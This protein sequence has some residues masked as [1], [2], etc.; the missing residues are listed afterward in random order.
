MKRLLFVVFMFL[1]G[2][3]ESLIGPNPVTVSSNEEKR[4]NLFKES[5]LNQR[6]GIS[7]VW[8]CG[9]NYYLKFNDR[10]SSCEGHYGAGQAYHDVN[11][12]GYQDIL[13]SFHPDN[14]EVNLTWYINSGDNINFT[15]SSTG[16]YLNQSTSGINSHKLL[17]TDVN[18]DGMADFIA[19]GVDET[20]PGNYTGNFT[21]LI[22][23]P[24]GKFD[25]N[26]IP[27]PNRYWFHNGAAG[28]INGDGNVDVITA[29][30]IWYGDGKG[31]F[32]RREDYNLSEYTPLV[33]E[34][35]DIN[36]DGWN[37]LILRGPFRETTIIY[38]NKGVIDKNS[39][40]YYL[41]AVTYKAVMDIEIVDFDK[42]G[43]LD[44]LE[45]SHLGGNSN[46][47]NVSKIT[48]F[49]NNQNY[50]VADEKILEESVDGNNLNNER[51]RFGW[52][53]F[54]VDDID[55]DGVDEI[56]AENYHD[57]NYNALKLIDGKWKKITINYGR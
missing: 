10:I 4:Y 29:T 41:P 48:V 33:Y 11:K 14:N 39:K 24:N 19:L 49:Y 5:V 40:I 7:F 54:K 55:R 38:N 2:C 23:K 37:D 44:I 3:R 35:I 26:D 20:I 52:S 57:G 15:K 53:V 42:D 12:D 8:G 51:D 25:V 28:D 1:V 9:E 36:K 16:Q 13:V 56:V 47:A 45:L 17:K 21:V 43:D 22:S 6:S 32:F 34:I 30:F 31:N 27:N 46:E 18:N 50:F